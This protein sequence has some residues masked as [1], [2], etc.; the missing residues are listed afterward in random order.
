MQIQHLHLFPQTIQIP[1]NESWILLDSENNDIEQ[2]IILSEGAEL[3]F[4]SARTSG[5]L[6]LRIIHQGADSISRIQCGF[7]AQKNGKIEAIIKSSFEANNATSEIHILS[8]ADS[9]GEV[10]LDSAIDIKEGT[11]QIIGRLKER[12]IFLGE[13]G[14]IRGIPALIVHSDDIEAS[15][16][17]AIDRI[18]DEELFYLR[19]RGF[20]R[21]EG[22]GLLL[23]GAVSEI[24]SELE[25]LD[26]RI[27]EECKSKIMQIQGITG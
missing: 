2:V 7:H 19:S 21:D 23:D 4:Y 5:K 26:E 27:Y 13:G 20:N 14:K 1:P 6:R 16:A 25:S 3:D 22:T 24:F 15:H 9:S 8:L 12:H 11:K 10:L 18:S 17:L